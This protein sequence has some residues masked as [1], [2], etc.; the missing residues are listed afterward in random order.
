M[1]DGRHLAELEEQFDENGHGIATQAKGL[2]ERQRKTLFRRAYDHASTGSGGML[3]CLKMPTI[4]SPSVTPGIS[5]HCCIVLR[6]P[7][8]ARSVDCAIGRSTDAKT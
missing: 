3:E 4:G 5:T 6:G 2:S 8:I 1:H 7:M